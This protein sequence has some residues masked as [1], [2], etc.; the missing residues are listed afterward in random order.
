MQQVH[1]LPDHTRILFLKCIRDFASLKWFDSLFHKS[2]PLNSVV[3]SRYI[4]VLHLLSSSSCI[5]LKFNPMWKADLYCWGIDILQP[6]EFG[7]FA[8]G[9]S[10]SHLNVIV[11]I[12]SCLWS[13]FCIIW[14]FTIRLSVILPQSI[15]IRGQYLKFDEIYASANTSTCS[16]LRNFLI[17]K[18]DL[19]LLFAFVTNILYMPFKISIFVS[20]NSK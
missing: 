5:F 15:E 19:V 16:R 10:F 12:W 7:D 14:V 13:C 17:R 8:Y 1:D 2:S 9:F 11:L 4:F 6:S 18:S 3:F 20:G